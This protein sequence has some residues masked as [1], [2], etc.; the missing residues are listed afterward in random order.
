MGAVSHRVTA[1]PEK[2]RGNPLS[3][4]IAGCRA[5][6]RS[7]EVPPRLAEECSAAESQRLAAAHLLVEWPRSEAGHRRKVQVPD[8]RSRA[9]GN[10]RSWPASAPCVP[11]NTC[12]GS[13]CYRAFAAWCTTLL[14]R[15]RRP[16]HCRRT[17][18]VLLRRGHRRRRPVF[19]RPRRPEWCPLRRCRPLR[20]RLLHPVSHRWPAPRTGDTTHRRIETDRRFCGCLALR[21]RWGWSAP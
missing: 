21:C 7:E 14:V 13:N 12:I 20:P 8:R 17:V 16:P 9:A 11:A 4:T 1:H 19:R 5:A 2:K 10:V 6:V 15:C 3:F 18:R